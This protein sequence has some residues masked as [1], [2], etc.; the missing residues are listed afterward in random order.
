MILRKPFSNF[1]W[2]RAWVLQLGVCNAV[3]CTWLFR[4]LE[5]LE[6]GNAAQ[7]VY[8]HVHPSPKSGPHDTCACQGYL[9]FCILYVYMYVYMYM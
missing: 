4:P 5:T 8:M 9:R 6:K 1:L 2:I 3:L 7:H